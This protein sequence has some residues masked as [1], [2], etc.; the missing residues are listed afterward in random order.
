MNVSVLEAQNACKVFIKLNGIGTAGARCIDKGEIP[1]NS[2]HLLKVRVGVLGSPR[3]LIRLSELLRLVMQTDS[4][5]RKNGRITVAQ[6]FAIS[7]TEHQKA[8]VA[9][10][11]LFIKCMQEIRTL[12]QTC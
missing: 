7:S 6:P 9:L 11:A 3:F 12:L 2:D 5:C 10:Q 8:A 1:G 4:K